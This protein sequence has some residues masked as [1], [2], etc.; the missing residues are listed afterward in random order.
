MTPHNTCVPFT[1]LAVS[2]KMLALVSDPGIF[3]PA[4]RTIPFVIPR[5]RCLEYNEYKEIQNEDTFF[6]LRRP[7]WFLARD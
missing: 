5:L 2:V 6:A 4:L 7:G 1:S 3:D